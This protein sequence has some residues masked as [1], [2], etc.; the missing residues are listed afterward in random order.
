MKVEMAV[1]GSPSRV[2]VSVWS[3]AVDVKLATLNKCVEAVSES[4]LCESRSGIP[5]AP[6]P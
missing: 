1:L 3:P 2:M 4:E 6:R 5:W